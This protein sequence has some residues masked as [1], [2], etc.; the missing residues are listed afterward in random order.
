MR[1]AIKKMWQGHLIWGVLSDG[2][3]AKHQWMVKTAVA[4]K[5][6]LVN[7]EVAVLH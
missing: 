3:R 4:I 5:A 6:V 1:T 2:F 7:R